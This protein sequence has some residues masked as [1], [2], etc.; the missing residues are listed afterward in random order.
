MTTP[1]DTVISQ[2][3]KRRFHNHR[4]QD[5]S[6]TVSEG[7][8]DDLLVRCAPL[9][10]D[11]ASGKV[12]RW[13]NVRTPGARQRKIDLL[14]GE[15]TPRGTPNLDELRICVEN[16]S[17]VTA[18]R[19]RDARFDDL[20]EALQV[21]HRVKPE[22][23]LVATVMIGVADRVLNVPDRIKP[24]YR[25]N[26]AKRILPRLSS[27]DALLWD[28]FP[29]AISRNEPDDPR[30]SV[31]KF[32]QLRTRPPGHTHVVGYD[33]VLLAPVYIDNVNPPYVPR[34]NKLDIDLDKEYET[35]LNQI[36]KA[37]SARWS[38]NGVT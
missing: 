13:L 12:R 27:G 25:K 20:N 6:N 31:D 28:R 32:R 33:Y 36:C 30:K 22:A 18:H 1:F 34:P 2:L 10:A 19:N 23:V 9:R 14:I 24:F 16:K 8:F 15:P 3:T 7:I 35:M 11:I 5:H 38:V 37:Y 17:V 21:L 26:F 29:D 4:Q